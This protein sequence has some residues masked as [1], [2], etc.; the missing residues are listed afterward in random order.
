MRPMKS[1]YSHD[2][3]TALDGLRGVA[4]LMVLMNHLTPDILM[5]SRILEWGK[6]L[7]QSGWIGV[8][9]FFVLSGFL[10]TG[11]LLRERDKPSFFLNFY[12]R[13]VLRIFPLYYLVVLALVVLAGVR[14][15]AGDESWQAFWDN[16]IWLWLH[17]V[18]IGVNV[19]GPEPF[20]FPPLL[21]FWSLSVEEHYYL[22]WPAVVFLVDSRR[23][24]WICYI[25]I[26]IAQLT[27]FFGVLSS[28]ELSPYWGMLTPYCMDYLAMGSLLA[29]WTQ[30]NA[31]VVARA[32]LLAFCSLFCGAMLLAIFYSEKGFWV[33]SRTLSMLFAGILVGVVFMATVLN[34][35]QLKP[36]SLMHRIV[37]NKSLCF[38]GKYSYGIYVFHPFV[39][40]ML[41]H[42][43]PI[44]TYLDVFGFPTLALIGHFTAITSATVVLSVA[45]WYAV[46]SRFLELKRYFDYENS[47]VKP[48]EPVKAGEMILR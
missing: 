35:T 31:N 16:Q 44:E 45:S 10:I 21:H 34:A 23:L 39:H 33:G 48:I 9:L 2:R 28:V 14:L 12:A 24:G 18:N 32:R 30:S 17:S 22:V 43:M 4:I 13:R 38:F 27:R 26:A 25:L 3:N 7:A 40:V 5:E 11:I 20:A 29:I 36:G 47:P 8:Q 37:A 6:K 1:T 41:D 19:E 15:S 46:E 42:Y